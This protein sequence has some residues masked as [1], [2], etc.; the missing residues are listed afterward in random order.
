MKIIPT[1]KDLIDFIEFCENVPPE[2][3]RGNVIKPLKLRDPGLRRALRRFVTF[4][5]LQFLTNPEAA[6]LGC[7]VSGMCFGMEMQHH[8]QE[9][10][11]LSKLANK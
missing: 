9:I 6:M 1:E 11:K 8:K 2:D 7:F 4:H 3:D 10:E 5:A